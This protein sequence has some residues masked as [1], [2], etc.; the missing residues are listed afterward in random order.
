MSEEIE[1]D[2]GFPSISELLEYDPYEMPEQIEFIV[3]IG[4]F[5]AKKDYLID[6]VIRA[7]ADYHS[8]EGEWAD[9]YGTNVDNCVFSLHRYCWCEAEDCKWCG[10][11]HAPN[12]YYKP[13]DFKVWW[14]KYIG[15]SMEYNKELTALQCADMLTECLKIRD[16]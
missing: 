4:M 13:L 11:E 3:P 7:I 12:F 6:S 9:K 16:N 10:E 14:Y 8:E 2:D 15:R 5:G 1:K